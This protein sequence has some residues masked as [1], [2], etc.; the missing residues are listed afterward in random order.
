[1]SRI[2]LFFVIMVSTRPGTYTYVG[3]IAYQRAKE[4]CHEEVDMVQVQRRG[5]VIW[6]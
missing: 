6:S 1:M 4:P 5:M 2:C 3:N